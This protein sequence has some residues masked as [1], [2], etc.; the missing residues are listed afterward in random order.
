[1]FFLKIGKAQGNSTTDILSLFHQESFILKSISISFWIV[2]ALAL[3]SI[4]LYRNRTLQIT[5]NRINILIN[6]ILLGLLAYYLLNLSGETT[7][8]MKGIGSFLPLLSIALLI[9]ANYAIK[10][11]ENLVKSIDRLR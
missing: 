11:D 1:I 8:S 10:K 7:V 3:V 5:I 4:F 2:S 9:L 6:L